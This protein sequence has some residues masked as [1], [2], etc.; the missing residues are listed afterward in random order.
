VTWDT[1]ETYFGQAFAQVVAFAA[2][3]PID[4]A[5]PEALAVSSDGAEPE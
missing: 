5:N 3:A 4:I 2:G 1:Y